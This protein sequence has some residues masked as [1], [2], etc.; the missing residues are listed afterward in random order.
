MHE[1]CHQVLAIKS[2]H[3]PAMSRN[4]VCKILQEKKTNKHI[5]KFSKITCYKISIC[6]C[7]LDITDFKENTLLLDFPIKYKGFPGGSDSKESTHNAGD[8][9]I[10]E[11]GRSPGGEHGNP[12]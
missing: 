12:L 3:Y 7:L 4:G 10:P 2:V 5:S 6:K 9:S 11:L 1:S 8:G